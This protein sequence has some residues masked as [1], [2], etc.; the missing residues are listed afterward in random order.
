MPGYVL[1]TARASVLS[2]ELTLQLQVGNCVEALLR[3]SAGDQGEQVVRVIT[4]T[5]RRLREGSEDLSG[6]P[7]TVEQTASAIGVL[8]AAHLALLTQDATSTRDALRAIADALEA[9]VKVDEP[10]ASV[11]SLVEQLSSLH[12]VLAGVTGALPDE[13]QAQGRFV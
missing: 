7:R 8:E 10:S 13:P 4:E 1:E 5:A 11:T 12:A 2:A 9:T 3:L 6:Q